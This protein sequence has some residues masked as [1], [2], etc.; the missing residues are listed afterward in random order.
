ME[1]IAINDLL[2]SFSAAT[3]NT[4][5]HTEVKAAKATQ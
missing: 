5:N 2:N 1:K 4:S 3:N